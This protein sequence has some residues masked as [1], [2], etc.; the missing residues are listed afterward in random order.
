MN[1]KQALEWLLT[2]SYRVGDIVKIP[3]ELFYKTVKEALAASEAGEL[4]TY[5]DLHSGEVLEARLFGA[6]RAARAEYDHNIKAYILWLY[7]GEELAGHLLI[8]PA[9]KMRRPQP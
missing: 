2:N 7:D 4:I 3:A 8:S 1:P 9:L 5:D 6:W